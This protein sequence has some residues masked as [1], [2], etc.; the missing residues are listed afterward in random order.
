[1]TGALLGLALG[2]GALLILLGVAA[3]RAVSPSAARQSSLKRLLDQA[4]LGRVRPSAVNGSC[5]G[6]A[7]V[8]GLL[9]LAV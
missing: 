3:P 5:L 8:S 6:L 4:G 1:M 2:L 9:V 7:L